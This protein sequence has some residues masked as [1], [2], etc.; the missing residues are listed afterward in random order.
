[1]HTTHPSGH[2]ACESLR[3]QTMGVGSQAPEGQT[4]EAVQRALAQPPQSQREEVVMDRRGGP[5]HL[6]GSLPAR[7]PL[8]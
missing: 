7:K 6:Q 8:G 4:G 3:Q 1:M 5:H 2:R